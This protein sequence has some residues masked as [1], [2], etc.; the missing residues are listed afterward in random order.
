MRPDYRSVI[1]SSIPAGCERALDVGCGL[2]DLTRVLR[3]VIPHV[4]GIDTD[5]RS[6]EHARSHPDAG[7]ITYLHG[8]FLTCSYRHLSA[9]WDGAD[10]ASDAMYRALKVTTNATISPLR[11]P[12]AEDGWSA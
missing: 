2:G 1:L 12:V 11:R 10:D 3:S 5:E 7:D 9:A 6:V 8:D 4:T